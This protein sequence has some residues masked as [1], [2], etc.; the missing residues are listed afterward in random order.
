MILVLFIS[1]IHFHILHIQLKHLKGD[2]CFSPGLFVKVATQS[3]NTYHHVW[4]FVK[5]KKDFIIF[6]EK[7]KIFEIMAKNCFLP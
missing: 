7:L 6:F 1:N 5:N 4:N 2:G 3:S